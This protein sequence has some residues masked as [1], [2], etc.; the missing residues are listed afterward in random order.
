MVMTLNANVF[1]QREWDRDEA[2]RFQERA[3]RMKLNKLVEVLRLNEDQELRFRKT[4]NEQQRIIDDT[5][6]TV[7]QSAQKLQEQ[8][9]SKAGDATITAA[10]DETR[11]A[12]ANLVKAQETRSQALRGLLNPKQYA[13]YILFELRF[14]EIMRRVMDRRR[15]E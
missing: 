3:Q 7:E 5:R 11:Q 10:T 8:L 15:G 6:R 2:E 9:R 12:A 4:Y 1:A 14:Q 13:K